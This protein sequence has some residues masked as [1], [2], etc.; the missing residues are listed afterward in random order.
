MLPRDGSC[1]I[2]FLL[3]FFGFWSVCLFEIGFHYEN[4]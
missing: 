4:L 2:L 1:D 3:L